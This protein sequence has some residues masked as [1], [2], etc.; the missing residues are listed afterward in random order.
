MLEEIAFDMTVVFNLLDKLDDRY[1]LLPDGIPSNLLKRLAAAL[2]LPLVI[3]FK[4]SLNTDNFPSIWKSALAVSKLKDGSK[5]ATS[6][7]R[8]ISLTFDPCRIL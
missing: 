6:S 5:S 3:F 8:P 4:E 2:A 1:T 7:Y